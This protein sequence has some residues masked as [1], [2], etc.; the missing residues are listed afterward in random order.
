MQYGTAV[1]T[2]TQN[3]QGRGFDS[4]PLQIRQVRVNIC[5]EKIVLYSFRMYVPPV[6]LLFFFCKQSTCGWHSRGLKIGLKVARAKVQIS[7]TANCAS[8]FN[9]WV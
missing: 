3:S 1:K 9:T 5:V 7:A 8:A 6:F 2:R 4:L